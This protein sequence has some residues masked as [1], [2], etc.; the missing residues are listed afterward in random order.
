VY[1][2][3]NRILPKALWPKQLERAT[4]AQGEGD[5]FAEVSNVLYVV[6]VYSKYTRRSLLPL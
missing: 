3:Y 5:C 1:S 4:V 6:T 2:E